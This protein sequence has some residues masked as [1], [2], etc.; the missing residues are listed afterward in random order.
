MINR[1]GTTIAGAA[2]AAVLIGVC[3]VPAQAAPP[4]GFWSS[5]CQD[6]RACISDATTDPSWWNANGCGFQPLAIWAWRGQAHGNRF[7]VTYQD[8]RWDEVQPWTTRS[9]DGTNPTRSVFV[10]C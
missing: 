2:A 7:R 8:G 6:G 4:T 3:A 10:Y 1:F 9:L 5:T